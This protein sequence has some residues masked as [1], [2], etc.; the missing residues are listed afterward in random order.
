MNRILFCMTRNAFVVG[1]FM[2]A[3]FYWGGLC[4]TVRGEQPEEQPVSVGTDGDADHASLRALVPMYEQAIHESKLEAFKPYL[5]PEFSGVMVTGEEVKGFQGLVDYWEEIQA[6]IGEGGTYR[7][8]VNVAGPAILSGDMAIAHGTTND[9]VVTGSGK[10]FEFTS[11]WTAVCRKRDGEWKV[12]RLQGT[13]DPIQNQFVLAAV[14]SASVFFGVIGLVVGLII[15]VLVCL[16]VRRCRG[17]GRK[18]P[19]S[20]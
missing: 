18:T 9:E 16:V 13:M 17:N 7:T 4:T 12:L 1:A 2:I 19:Q 5:D 14:Q 11:Q 8:K 6:L 3:I 10:K 20:S 15:G